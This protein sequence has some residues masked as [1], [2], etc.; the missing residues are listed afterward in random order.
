MSSVR[1]SR[2]TALAGAVAGGLSGVLAAA[3]GG[4]AAPGGGA[5]GPAAA[6]SFAGKKIEVEYWEQIS[7]PEG[8]GRSKAIGEFNGVVPEVSLK[9]TSIVGQGGLTKVQTA[10][11]AGG[12]GPDVM[13]LTWPDA[14]VLSG[15][16]LIVPI[17][18]RLR[19]FREWERRKT[20]VGAGLLKAHSWKGRL[21]SVPIYGGTFAAYYNKAMLTRR[22][23][24][25]PKPGWTWDDF[26]A[27]AAKFADGQDQFG[28][29]LTDAGGTGTMVYWWSF[30]GS[31]NASLLS[32]DGTKVTATAPEVVEAT[33]FLA[34]LARRRVMALS[35][36]AGGPAGEFGQQKA[37]Y[38]MNGAYRIPV[39]QQAGVDFAVTGLPVKRKKHT[40][41]AAHHA[42]LFNS[43]N[44][45]KIAGGARFVSWALEPKNHIAICR[46]A[47]TVPVYGE[48]LKL[49]AHEDYLRSFPELKTFEEY[50]PTSD[51]LPIH[52]TASDF[53]A[54]F[55]NHLARA[56]RG[57]AEVRRALMDAQAEMEVLLDKALQMGK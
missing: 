41:V 44:A 31:N 38:E 30:A 47:S 57:E 46:Q 28:Y 35:R 15:T 3:C 18:E 17:E 10:A 40:Y 43:G 36:T 1:G 37:A 16:E 29:S 54:A 13:F 11:A 56:L 21:V 50:V 4:G 25:P 26:A 49:P 45:D 48:A 39:W 42:V 22:N 23:V 32:P 5:A 12:G 9:V 24:A 7:G 52:P 20:D 6:P 55:G 33:Q 27:D 2:R 34:D 19:P 14:A 53:Y 51:A 8:D